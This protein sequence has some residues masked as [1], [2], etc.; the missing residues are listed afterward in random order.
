MRAMR[1]SSALPVWWANRSERTNPS[2]TALARMP[3]RP[4]SL[5]IDFIRPIVDA[6]VVATPRQAALA[7]T[8]RVAHERHDRAFDA[9]IDHVA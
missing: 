4:N 5:A 2:D 3:L 8:A 1:S 6:R 9:R 7:H